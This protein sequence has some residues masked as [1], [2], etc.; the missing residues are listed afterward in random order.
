MRFKKF[1]E[2][3]HGCVIITG[4]RNNYESRFIGQRD[5]L[6]KRSSERE[7]QRE[8]QNNMRS[9]SW[10]LEFGTNSMVSDGIKFALTHAT[11]FH[12]EMK[13]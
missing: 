4:L 2:N 13:L 5:K 12:K 11:E 7:A 9:L 6:R 1:P 8:K 3:L 10:G